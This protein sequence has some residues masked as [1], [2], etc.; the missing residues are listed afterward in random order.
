MPSAG[1][2]P[3]YPTIPHMARSLTQFHSCWLL[4]S[5][6]INHRNL[7][8]QGLRGRNGTS[9]TGRS[10]P[11]RRA[12]LRRAFGCDSLSAGLALPSTARSSHTHSR[13]EQPCPTRR[14]PT[15]P[16]H[17]HRT[18]PP[19]HP[20]RIRRR[21]RPRLR[22]RPPTRWLRASRGHRRPPGHQPRR[23]RRGRRLR[24]PPSGRHNRPRRRGR[25]THRRPR[26]RRD[27]SGP[28]P[29]G[30]PPPAGWPTPAGAP[31]ASR[32]AAAGPAGRRP[33]IRRRTPTPGIRRSPASR[34]RAAGGSSGSSSRPSWHSS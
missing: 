11:L 1:R 6:V 34:P 16:P 32:L 20:R 8:D 19:P 28:T 9:V 25:P 22:S 2:A 29:A 3:A 18:R 27:A 10:R 31:P 26:G 24:P 21:R 12:G 5:R 23:P 7:S 17:P 33:A 15:R 13:P 14:R 4:E 30:S